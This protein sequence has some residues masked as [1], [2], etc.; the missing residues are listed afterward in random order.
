MP[1]D[2]TT[3]PE[4]RVVLGLGGCVDTEIT[5]DDATWQDLADQHRITPSEADPSVPVTDERAL[6]RSVLGFLREGAGGER[7]LASPGLVTSFAA[8]FPHRTTL[9]G[10][11]VRAAL[12]LSR[13]GLPSSLHLV[14][15]DDTVRRLLPPEVGYLCSAPRDSTWPHLI[16]QFPAGAQVRLGPAVLRAPHPNRVIYV[17]D[18]PNQQMLLSPR[19]DELLA[20]ARLFLISGFNSMQDAATLDARLADLARHLHRLPASAVVLFEDAGY[21]HPEHSRHVVAGLGSRVDMHSMN[22]DELQAHLG[23]DVE[24]L[25][26]PALAAALHEARALLPARTLVVHTKYWCLAAGPDAARYRPALESATR[27]AATRYLHG[28]TFTR[29]DYHGIAATGRHPG[30]LAVARQLEALLPGQ[31]CCVPAL[32]P[33]TPTPTTI[34]LGDAFVGGFIAGLGDIAR[35]G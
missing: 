25:N 31:V 1:E 14:S 7:P 21:H 12:T 10:T 9:G 5:W 3:R 13:I 24:L 35:T 17:N 8:R 26:A 22:E 27:A 18:P 16:V 28:D 2:G 23:R 29:A 15:V 30:G 34:G 33:S 4:G 20:D 32:A 19:L 11:N 6:V